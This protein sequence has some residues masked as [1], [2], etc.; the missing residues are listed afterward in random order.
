[1]LLLFEEFERGRLN[2]GYVFGSDWNYLAPQRP[3]MN[4][5]VPQHSPCLWSASKIEVPPT[6]VVALYI[7]I[8]KR[9]LRPFSFQTGDR[10]RHEFSSHRVGRINYSCCYVDCETQ[11]YLGF[12]ASHFLF[13]PFIHRL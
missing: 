13:F 9:G 6:F 11:F 2:F 4:V 12:L 10:P 8:E 3:N 5:I 7:G 1:M